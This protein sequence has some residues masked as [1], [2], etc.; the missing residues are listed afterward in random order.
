[1]EKY[2]EVH[3]TTNDVSVMSTNVKLATTSGTINTS[4][5]VN[6]IKPMLKTNK[7]QRC[8]TVKQVKE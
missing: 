4:T 1:L 2:G 3:V 5:N 8:D 6:N 7:E